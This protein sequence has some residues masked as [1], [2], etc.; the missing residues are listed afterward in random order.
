MISTLKEYVKKTNIKRELIKIELIEL[1]TNL[2]NCSYVT[3]DIFDDL[4]ENSN[5]YVCHRTN[6][7]TRIYGAITLIIER[8]FIHNGQYVC[9][10]EDVV[11]S[12]KVT[13]K[14]YG[15]EM[16]NYAI[17]YSKNRGCYKIILN[18]NDKLK[19]YYEKFGFVNKNHEMS[20]Y[21]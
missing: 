15:K 17:E 1:Y 19:P 11:V 10:V 2:S 14:G 16:I 3:D 8:K 13:G 6:D 12:E 21:Y 20:L 7:Y 5:I 9:H 18:C 4:I